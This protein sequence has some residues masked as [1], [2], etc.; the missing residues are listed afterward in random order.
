MPVNERDARDGV[1]APDAASPF[2]R[3]VV[4]RASRRERGI[5]ET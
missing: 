3:G 1:V 5:G 2:G 4:V